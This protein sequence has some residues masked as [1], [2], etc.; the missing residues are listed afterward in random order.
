MNASKLSEYVVGALVQANK[1]KELS[2]KEAGE[3]PLLHDMITLSREPGAQGTTVARA[4]GKLLGWPVYDHELLDYIGKEMGTQV[5]VL[6]LIDEKPMSWLEQCV[7]DL[8]SEYNL[9]QDS[10]MVH[11]IATLRGLAQQGHCV[12]VGRGANFVLPHDTTLNVRLVANLKHR[13]AN[14]QQGKQLPEKEAARWVE[15]T[16]RERHDF[17]KRHFG[18]E[19]GDPHL[20]DLVLNSARLSVD[21]CADVIVSTLHRLQARNH[22]AT[23]PRGEMQVY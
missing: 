13:I 7:V 11:L 2:K 23:R 17:V 1:Y 16:D 18:K 4:V 9:S 12:I 22:A 10:Y 3:P 5:N 21:E 8:V 19:V 14:I 15:K 20:Y 6:K